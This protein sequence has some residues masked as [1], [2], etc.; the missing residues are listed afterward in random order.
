MNTTLLIKYIHSISKYTYKEIRKVYDDVYN[1]H[2]D[3]NKF[4]AKKAWYKRLLALARVCEINKACSI[5]K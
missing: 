4:Y 1:K 5:D 2:P 3:R